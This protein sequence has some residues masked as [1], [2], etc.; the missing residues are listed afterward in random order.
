LVVLPLTLTLPGALSAVPAIIVTQTLVE[1]I[2]EL[3]YLRVIPRLIA[4]PTASDDDSVHSTV[5]S[6]ASFS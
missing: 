3:V 4:T 2:G 1:L 5:N 6:D